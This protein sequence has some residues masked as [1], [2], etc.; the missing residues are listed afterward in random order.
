MYVKRLAPDSIYPVCE[1]VLI[2]ACNIYVCV[3]KVA[4]ACFVQQVCKHVLALHCRQPP[5]PPWTSE[6]I[7]G[8]EHNSGASGSVRFWRGS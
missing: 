7:V 6:H 2:Y 3:K 8:G 5:A 1:C 4:G